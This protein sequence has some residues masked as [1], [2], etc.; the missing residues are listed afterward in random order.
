MLPAARQ[1]AREMSMRGAL[2]PWRTISGEE[3]SAYYAAGTAQYHINADIAYAVY[4]YVHVTGDT[5]FLYSQGVDILVETARMWAD[6][7]FWRET[8]DDRTFHIHSVTGPDE[9]TTVVNN[10]LYT[11]VMAR[12]NLTRAAAVVRQ[13]KQDLP[14][15]YARVAKR[16]DLFDDEP[17]E[18]QD[19]ANGMFIPYDET[20]EVH[21]QDE[22]FLERE[23]WDLSYTTGIASFIAALSSAGDLPVP[24]V[25]AG[26]CGAG[27]VLAG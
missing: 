6:L 5:E 24:G 27:P 3:A 22:H 14:D 11:N 2:F 25:E 13:L 19:C 21:P 8:D 9:Y 15:L 16:L 4:K 23:L 10:N 12:Y 20:L 1:R 26:R 17:Q 7:G 18:W